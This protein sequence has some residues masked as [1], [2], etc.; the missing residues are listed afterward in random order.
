MAV[1][2]VPRPDRA[3]SV[4]RGAAQSAGSAFERA[5]A[6]VGGGSAVQSA[7][8]AADL[9]TGGVVSRV[10]Q[11]LG[12]QEQPDPDYGTVSGRPG[13]NPRASLRPADGSPQWGNL[14]QHLIA[15]IYALDDDGI[16][17]FAEGDVRGPVTEAQFEATLNWQSPFEAT[18]P[19][20][21]APALMAMLQTGQI[22]TLA[23]AVQAAGYSGPGSE[24]LD[25]LAQNTREAARSLRG[26]TGITKLNSRQVFSGMPPIK[27]TMM[28][29]FRAM[30]DPVAEVVNPYKRLLEWALPKELAEDGVLAGIIRGDNSGVLSSLFPSLAPTM[31]GFSYGNNRYSPMVIESIGNA[32]DGPMGP[33]GL[34]V[35][36]AVQLTLATLTAL[37]KNDVARIF[38][39]S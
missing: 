39:R 20:S 38:S 7:V 31:I 18:G 19:E 37:D 5:A 4:I 2:P 22:A 29:H 26:R 17:S 12:V 21:K 11:I 32:I 13:G 23:S 28:M 33:T 9:A 14:S 35:Y 16:E 3:V 15:R 36:R 10:G 25:S 27:L 34:P 24:H 6:S 30:T 1:I 8:R